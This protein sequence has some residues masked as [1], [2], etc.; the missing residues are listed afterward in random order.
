MRSCAAH[1]AAM[2]ASPMRSVISVLP[3][4]SVI[5]NTRTSLIGEPQAGGEGR[6]MAHELLW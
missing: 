6:E 4:T 1:T 3:T 2:A 5:T